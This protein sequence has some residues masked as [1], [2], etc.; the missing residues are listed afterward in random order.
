MRVSILI[1]G[2]HFSGSC[3]EIL[4][5]LSPSIATFLLGFDDSCAG[6][7]RFVPL[8][9]LSAIFLVGCGTASGRSCV[10]EK[11]CPKIGQSRPNPFFVADFSPKAGWARQCFWN[12]RVIDSASAAIECC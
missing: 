8:S 7:L 6:H 9:T 3:R 5:F 1:M 11:F 2:A 10:L 12:R 4:T